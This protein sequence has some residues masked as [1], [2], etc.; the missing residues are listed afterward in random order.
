[1]T[2]LCRGKGER[3]RE[4]T[5][6]ARRHRAG[7]S[8]VGERRLT[9]AVA[10]RAGIDHGAAR[11]GEALCNGVGGREHGEVA[12]RSTSEKTGHTGEEF[13]RLVR[14]NLRSG[15]FWEDERQQNASWRAGPSE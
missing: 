6:T 11:R 10:R 15:R 2:A 7:R 3:G 13:V 9:T 12:T 5:S 8:E 14:R 1:M 4:I